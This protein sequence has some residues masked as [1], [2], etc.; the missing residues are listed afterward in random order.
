MECKVKLAGIRIKSAWPLAN[1]KFWRVLRRKLA[2]L[3]I[4]EKSL[5]GQL[6]G[7]IQDKGLNSRKRSSLWVPG[8]TR[9]MRFKLVNPKCIKYK[10]QHFKVF[11]HVEFKSAMCW[12]VYQSGSVTKGWPQ[13]PCPLIEREVATQTRER[14][15][16]R[17][18][19]NLTLLLDHPPGALRGG[20]LALSQVLTPLR[21]YHSK[22][23]KVRTLTK[24]TQ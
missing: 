2:L 24:V 18:G 16:Y 10:F 17:M 5:W 1:G 20:H 3:C 9:G 15:D 4:S 21:S 7:W 12:V 8:E 23:Q 22:A 19:K 14:I 13:D 11:Y 6:G